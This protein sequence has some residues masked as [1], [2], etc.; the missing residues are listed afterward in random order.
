MNVETTIQPAGSELLQRFLPLTLILFCLLPR[1]LPA[2]GFPAEGEGWTFPTN[3]TSWT[4]GDTNTWHDDLDYAPISFT[5]LA[6]SY[7]G[8]IYNGVSLSLD[9]T[10]PAWLRYNMQEADGHTNLAVESGSVILW[11][12]PGWASAN[13]N[14]NGSGPGD[15]GRLLEV[16]AYSTNASYG[17]W[18]LYFDSGGTNIY[19]ATQTN[20]GDGS[21]VILLSAPIN[22]ATNIWHSIALT[23]STTNTALYLDGKLSASGAGLSV[24]PGPEVQ[25]DGFGIGSDSNG[26]AQAHGL[27]DDIYTFGFPLDAVTVSSIYLQLRGAYSINIFN[28]Q[29]RIPSAPPVPTG[30][31]VFNAISGL[32]WLQWLGSASNCV[33]SSDVWMTNVSSTLAGVG[34]NQTATC[35]F[36]MA[37]GYSGV[38]Y[39]V[40]A[41][42]ALGTS[43]PAY[44]WGWL[45]QGYPCNIYSEPNLPVSGAFLILGTPLDRDMD[46]LTDAYENLVSKTD[47]LNPDSDGD[48]LSDYY[49]VIAGLSPL[50]GNAVPSLSSISIPTCPVP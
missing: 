38:G 17:W 15:W 42:A 16:G 11:F 47:P 21:A 43:E 36:T 31:S 5:N 23:Y 24:F 26:L 32:G 30:P 12:A 19:F 40:F 33:T 50:T 28:I 20:S 2:Q 34:T 8:N 35:M 10:N 9:S 4:F 49:E 45:G 46:G 37:G 25:A 39:D 22:W 7:M 6:S 27:F 13:T 41:T 3:L 1:M 48:G 44:G 18:S 14:Q 29:E